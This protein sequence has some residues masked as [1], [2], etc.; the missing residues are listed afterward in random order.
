MTRREPHA[1]RITDRS[2][3]VQMVLFLVVV[4]L[5]LAG[6]ALAAPPYV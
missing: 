1:H 5:V 4:V 3:R 6:A 2:E